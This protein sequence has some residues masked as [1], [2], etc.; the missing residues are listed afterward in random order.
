MA[1]AGTVL[2]IRPALQ[3]LFDGAPI[4]EDDLL[5][6]RRRVINLPWWGGLVSAVAW[7]LCIP[8]FLTSLD[9]GAGGRMDP[10]LWWHLPI[11]FIVS[12]FISITHSF[13]LIELITQKTL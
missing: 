6:A 7:L 1:W 3:R 2:S 10:M 4:G 13:F 5:R 12:A 8:V 9:T 11:S